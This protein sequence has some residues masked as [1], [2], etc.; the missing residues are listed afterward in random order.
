MTQLELFEDYARR[1]GAFRRGA[2]RALLSFIAVLKTRA[3]LARI[4]RDSQRSYASADI[5]D[6]LRR[7][8]GLPE[9]DTTPWHPAIIALTILRLK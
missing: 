3:A 5:P 4:T 2:V 1:P 6:H 8:L 9:L 7:D